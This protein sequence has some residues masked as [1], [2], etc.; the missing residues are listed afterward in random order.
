VLTDEVFETLKNPRILSIAVNLIDA[1]DI[2]RIEQLSV[3]RLLFEHLRTSNLT[4]TT[5]LS[6]PEFAKA[7]KELGAVVN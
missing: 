5:N 1:R 7:L 3:G 6:P 2:E 4:G